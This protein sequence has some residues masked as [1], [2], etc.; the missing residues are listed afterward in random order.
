MACAVRVETRWGR[1]SSSVLTMPRKNGISRMSHRLWSSLITSGLLLAAVGCASWSGTSSDPTPLPSPKMATDCIILEVTFVRLPIELETSD[2]F[3]QQVDEQHLATDIRRG[4]GDNGLRTGLVG[5]QLPECLRDWLDRNPTMLDLVSSELTSEESQMFSRQ[6]RL[7]MRDG[8]S[9]R[10]P[11]TAG[12]AEEAVVLLRDGDLV[13]AM[14]FERP[15]GFFVIGSTPLGDGRVQLELTPAVEF[16]QVRQ[17]WVGGQGSFM[18]D[19]D[20]PQQLFESLRFATVLSPGQTLLVSATPEARGVGGHFFAA[21]AGEQG[22]RS[23]MLVR[24]AQTQVD[25]LF[26]PPDTRRPL[27]PI[28]D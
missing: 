4:M 2:E 28:G 10:I 22:Q 14:R 27:T 3:W 9:K 15:R 16:G 18:L 6:Q 1:C 26:D 25:D 13:R 7:Q 21:E 8:R 24:L 11:A 19:T 23:L 17:R 5:T 12:K 20:R